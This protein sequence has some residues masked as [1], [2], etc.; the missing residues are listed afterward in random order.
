MV[1]WSFNSHDPAYLVAG[2]GVLLAT[3][4][5]SSALGHRSS[6]LPAIVIPAQAAIELGQ[7][8]TDL[9]C[10]VYMLQFDLPF[11]ARS[12]SRPALKPAQS[13]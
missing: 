12:Y 13:C 11:A 9:P 6:K 10:P 5:R 1:C 8:F 4:G 2:Q 3:K 7:C